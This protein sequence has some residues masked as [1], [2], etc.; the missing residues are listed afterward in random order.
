MARPTVRPAWHAPRLVPPA[1]EKRSIPIRLDA[2]GDIVTRCADVLNL[3][4]RREP[5][6]RCRT[7]ETERR[8]W[9]VDSVCCGLVSVASSRGH[10]CDEALGRGASRMGLATQC[11]VPHY[12]TTVGMGGSG[13]LGRLVVR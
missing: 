5:S 8:P 2:V 1:P 7:R 3:K 6:Y 11:K 10:P 4:F 12:V 13:V 9:R